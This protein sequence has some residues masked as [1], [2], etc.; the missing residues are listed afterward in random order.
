[1]R[2]VCAC[3]RFGDGNIVHGWLFPKDG[4][5]MT[6]LLFVHGWIAVLLERM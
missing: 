6:L 4:T 2:S 3:L 5:G 1:M